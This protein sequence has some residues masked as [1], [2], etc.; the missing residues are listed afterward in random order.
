MT[1]KKAIMLLCTPIPLMSYG[2]SEKVLSSAFWINKYRM[3]FFY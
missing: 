1:N 2:I 3:H